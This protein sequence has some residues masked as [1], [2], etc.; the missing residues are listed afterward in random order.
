MHAMSMISKSLYFIDTEAIKLGVK[1][2][3][4]KSTYVNTKKEGDFPKCSSCRQ[5][6][7][8]NDQIQ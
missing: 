8:C 7:H 5:C 1:K 2:A 4:S 6:K 3:D